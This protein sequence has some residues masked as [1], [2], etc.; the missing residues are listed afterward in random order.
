L[1]T[2][3]LATCVQAQNPLAGT[4]WAFKAHMNP[5]NPQELL[6]GIL[7][8]VAIEHRRILKKA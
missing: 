1:L 7:Q 4:A 8:L 2:A 5:E 6:T 3:A